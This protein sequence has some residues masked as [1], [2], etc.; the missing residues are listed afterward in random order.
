MLHSKFNKAERSHILKKAAQLV[1]YADC[2]NIGKLVKL[3]RSANNYFMIFKEPV[4]QPSIMPEHVNSEDYDNEHELK[5]KLN[6]K[7]SIVID[8]SFGEEKEIK[9]PQSA[10]NL[11]DYLIQRNKPI[12]LY[13]IRTIIYDLLLTLQQLRIKGISHLD[14]QPLN[15]FVVRD[16]GAEESIR[17]QYM[18]NGGGKFEDVKRGH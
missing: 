14:V 13:E 6:S 10:L 9:V 18:S 3:Y 12:N 15:L 7:M 5:A 11:F 17:L 1:S 2:P 8:D 16:F 4:W